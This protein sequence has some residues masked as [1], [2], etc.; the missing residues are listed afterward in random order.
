[1]VPFRPS[2]TWHVKTLLGASIESDMWIV[3]EARRPLLDDP[4][5][6][7]RLREARRAGPVRVRR[8]LTKHRVH[9]CVPCPAL[10]G[11]A[12]EPSLLRRLET[13]SPDACPRKAVDALPVLNPSVRFDRTWK[14]PGLS[15]RSQLAPIPATIVKAVTPSSHGTGQWN[16]Q[17]FF[18]DVLP[19]LPSEPARVV[20]RGR[21]PTSGD[22]AEIELGESTTSSFSGSTNSSATFAGPSNGS[23]SRDA[24][25]EQEIHLADLSRECAHG[26]RPAADD[27]LGDK[28]QLL[29]LVRTV[30][31]AAR[32]KSNSFEDGGSR[33][34]SR[35]LEPPPTLRAF[36]A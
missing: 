20:G 30:S 23:R 8:Q 18:A 1:M 9:N 36:A 10:R 19:I 32:R 16:L 28:R 24:L 33:R 15:S 22:Q 35:L 27:R 11:H 6:V 21:R 4:N 29:L 14:L 12:I 13:I 17:S 26:R 2:S 5:V 7:P 31:P 34:M 3:F 25:R